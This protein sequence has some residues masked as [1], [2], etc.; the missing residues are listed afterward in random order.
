MQRNPREH[1]PIPR[2]SARR[3]A[4]TR[5]RARLRVLF[6]IA[7]A[8]TFILAAGAASGLEPTDVTPIPDSTFRQVVVPPSSGGGLAVPASTPNL[9]TFGE[10]MP[11]VTLPD[12]P[13]PSIAA[14]KPIVKTIAPP[15]PPTTHSIRG[16]ASWYCRAGISP[17]TNTHLDGSGFDAYGAAGPAL[18]A[19]IGSDWRGMIVTVDGIR[20][21]L[22]DWCQCYRGEPSEKLID[23]YY[24]VYAR[25]GSAIVIRW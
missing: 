17:C 10:P 24:D 21:K 7:L 9:Q 19:A 13:T 1:R 15:P 11:S 6:S 3:P 12:R 8:G 2:I 22:I 14:P 5:S 4:H 25:T 20:V 18:R 23:L 16:A